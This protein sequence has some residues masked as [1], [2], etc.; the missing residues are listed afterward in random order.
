M[1]GKE[2]RLVATP[3]SLR[4]RRHWKETTNLKINVPEWLE[5]KLWTD[6]NT[7]SME[8]AEMSLTWDKGDNDRFL[9]VLVPLKT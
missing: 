1:N 4:S 9:S 5:L 2:G 3:P 7:M 8:Q 6:H